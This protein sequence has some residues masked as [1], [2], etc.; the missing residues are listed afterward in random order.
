MS[1]TIKILLALLLIGSGFSAPALAVSA[2]VSGKVT[3]PA[4]PGANPFQGISLQLEKYDAESDSYT[5]VATVAI[6][7]SP[8]PTSTTAPYKFENVEDGTYRVSFPLAKADIATSKFIASSSSVF[9]IADSKI[10]VSGRSVSAIPDFKLTPMGKFAVKAV[11]PAT[12]VP[13]AD[14]VFTLLGQFNGEDIELGSLTAPNDQ[15]TALLPVPIADT[16]TV[17]IV[18]PAGLH[19]EFTIDKNFTN[20]PSSSDNPTVY[21][22]SPA[23]I[24]SVTVTSGGN[25]VVGAVVHLMDVDT[26]LTSAVANASGIATISGLEPRDYTIRVGG[27]MGS[28][29][30]DSEAQPFTINAGATTSLTQQLVA[31]KTIS[32]AVTGSTD[33]ASGVP[34]ANVRVEIY[35]VDADGNESPVSPAKTGIDGT[36]VSNGLSAG[37][38]NLY[39]YDDSSDWQDYRQSES[40]QRVVVGNSN[41]TKQNVNLPSAAVVTGTV[42]TGDGGS[43]ANTLAEVINSF[44]D[45]IAV[46]QV[47]NDGKFRFTK[48]VPGKYSLK[49][50]N[51]NYLTA[52]TKDFIAAPNTLTNKDITLNS[53]S[54]ISGVVTAAK[55]GQGIDGV[56]VSAYLSSGAGLIPALTVVTGMDGSYELS[57]LPAG[58]YR[59]KYDGSGS[60]TPIGIFWQADSRSNAKSFGQ[61]V[62]IVTRPGSVTQNVNPVPATPWTLVT[63]KVLGAG[64]DEN[65]DPATVGLEN[66]TVTLVST[67]GLTVRSADTTA[68]GVFSIAVPDGNYGIKIAAV[69]YTTGYVGSTDGIATLVPNFADAELVSVSAGVAQFNN[70]W[71]ITDWSIDV[72][73]AGGTV[74]VIVTDENQDPVASG[75]LVAYDMQGNSVAFTDQCDDAGTFTL[76]GLRGKYYFSYESPGEFAKRFVGGTVKQSDAGTEIVKVDPAGKPKT[77]KL[78]TVSLPT[79]NLKLVTGPGVN[80][81]P[82]IGDVTVEVYTQKSG[83]WLRNDDLTTTAS[84]GSVALGVASGASYRIRVVPDSSEFAPIWVGA[85]PLATNVN[86]AS[87]ILIPATGKAPTLGNVVLNVSTGGISGEVSDSFA[88]LVPSGQVQLLDTDGKVLQTATTRDDGTYRIYRVLPGTYSL[89]FAAEGLA[90]KYAYNVKVEGRQTT[91]VSMTLNSATGV[92]GLMLTNDGSAVVG[93]S[94]SIFAAGGSGV[95]PINTVSTKSDGSYN[96]TGIPAGTYKIKFDG[97]TAEIP[98]DVFW[99][100][101]SENVDTFKAGS[102]VTTATGQS[103]KNINPQPSNSWALIK[104]TILDDSNVVS[105]ASISLVTSSGTNSSAKVVASDITDENANFALYAPDGQYKI[106]VQAAGFASGFLDTTEGGDVILSPTVNGAAEV[107]VTDNVAV[108]DN[109]AVGDGGLNPEN[110]TLDLA[111]TGGSLTVNVKDENGKAITDGSVT[112]YDSTGNVVAYDDKALSGAFTISGLSG[113]YRFSYVQDGVFAKTFYGDTSDI[114]DTKT[115]SL[116]VNKSIKPSPSAT[117]NVKTL[118]KITVNIVDSAS[119]AASFKQP[120]TVEVYSQ[121]AGTWTLNNSLTQETSSGSVSFGVSNLDQ[122]RIR[123]VPNSELLTPVWVG[124]ARLATSVNLASTITI[125]A[126]GA[127]PT[128]GKVVMNS[129]AGVIQ[130]TVLDQDAAGILNASVSL[131]DNSGAEIESTNSRA[132]GSYRFVQEFPGTY[133]IKIVADGYAVKYVKQFPVVGG[134]VNPIETQLTP[135]TGISGRVLLAGDSQTPVVG[136]AVS[137]YSA[138]GTGNIAIQTVQTDSD[139]NYNFVGLAP[140]NYKVYF[141]NRSAQIPTASFW[142]GAETNSETFKDASAISATLGSYA[143]GV[144][145]VPS[146]AWTLFTGNIHD[147]QWAVVGGSVSLVS[148]SLISLAGGTALTGV[149]DERGNFAIY[150]PDGSYRIKVSAPGY[151]VGYIDASELGTPVLTTSAASAAVLSVS[152]GDLSF[153]NELSPTEINLDLGAHGGKVLVTV[154]DELGQ[155]VSDGVVSA[156]DKSGAVV[157]QVNSSVGG[158]FTLSGLFG[159][160]RLSY[161][162]DGIFAE[163]FL[164]DTNS[165][166]SAG[167]Q[168]TTVTNGSSISAAI[169]VK[170]LPRLTVNIYS[171]GTTAY[172]QPTLVEVYT[173]DAGEWV[174]NPGLTQETSDGVLTLGVVNSSQYRIRLVPVDPALAPIWL[175]SNAS[176]QSVKLAKS[177]LIPAAGAVPAVAGVLNVVSGGLGGLLTDS[178]ENLMPGVTVD[179]LATNSDVVAETKTLEDGSYSF[180]QLYPGTYKVKF[181]LERFADKV[182]SVSVTAGQIT[183][184]D[185]VLDSASG[186]SGRVMGTGLQQAMR[187]V[188]LKLRSM[189]SFDSSSNIPVAGA[190]VG[191]YLASGNG[192]TPVRTVT[193]DENGN[194]NFSGLLPGS[195]RIRIDGN[196]ATKPAERIWYSNGDTNA[197]TF[198]QASTIEALQGELVTDIEPAPIKFWTVFDGLLKAG[199]NSISSGTVTLISTAGDSYSA[200]TDADGFFTLFA[201]DGAYRVRVTAAGYPS[202]YVNDSPDGVILDTVSA[203]ATTLNIAEGNAS[204]TTGLDLMNSPLDLASFGGSL[205]VQVTDGNT[206]LTDGVVTVYNRAGAVVAYTDV[207]SGGFFNIDGLKGDYKVSYE[208]PGSYDLSFI[209]DTKSVSDPDTIFVKVRDK[210]VTSAKVNA[211]A[212]PKFTVSV[213]SGS[214]VYKQ[215][216]SINVFKQDGQNWKL[217]PD[218]G[219]STFTGSYVFGAVRGENYRVQVVPDDL[220]TSAAWV[221]N[222]SALS[223]A[224]ALTYSV[225]ATGAAP[226]LPSV[227]LSPAVQVTIPLKNS[228]PVALENVVAHLEVTANGKLVEFGTQNAGNLAVDSSTELTFTRVP[229][230]MFP[231]SVTGTSSN[232]AEVSS[233]WQG[234]APN[235]DAT[236]DLLEFKDEA[237]PAKLSGSVKTAAGVAIADQLVTLATDEGEEYASTTTDVEGYYSFDSLPLGIHLTVKSEANT[238]FLISS[239]DTT[240]TAR[241]GKE[242]EANFT[243]QDAV[244]FGGTVLDASGNPKANALVNVYQVAGVKLNVATDRVFRVYTD[245]SGTW[246][247]DGTESRAGVGNY[248]F[249]ADGLGADFTP[250]YLGNLDC[251]AKATLPESKA[252]CS[253][254]KPADAV[255]V[256]ASQEVDPLSEITLVLGAPDRT[257]PTGVKISKAPLAITTVSP[258]WEWTGTDSVDG[259]AL[260]SEVLVA[261]AS[262]GKP[263]SAWS[264]PIDVAGKSYSIGGSR[265]ATYC[266]SVSMVDKSGNTSA[267]TAPSC[268]TVAMD[269]TAMKPAVAGLW[270]QAA[271]PGAVAGKVIAAKKNAK[272][273]VLNINKAAAGKSLCVYYVTGA[274]FGAFTVTVNGKALGKPVPTAGKAGQIKSV[275]YKTKLKAKAKIAI[276]VAKAGNGVQIDGYAITIANAPAPAAPVAALR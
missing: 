40:I 95:T 8:S 45:A 19:Q 6:S 83:E 55:T 227:S 259:K 10:T 244:Q 79:L 133:T 54:V 181:A 110:L 132:D 182:A 108:I 171:V 126:S 39:F 260:R 169:K 180:I 156:Y 46:T 257:A 270:A 267:Y 18:D 191:L 229:K 273:A 168:T 26:E 29:L 96:L 188:G 269:D 232:S 121:V 15:G 36:F 172:K 231:I 34:V 236:T 258:A 207:V 242:L 93:A 27:P 192:L 141:N 35:Q 145:P 60:S 210:A 226:L 144:D 218:L 237:I 246:S 37:T 250:A 150:A 170:T 200:Q 253:V 4:A 51:D 160:Y 124:D 275:C 202:G 9:V 240:F 198:A 262:Y 234:A 264:K 228:R 7:P 216:V 165:L 117:I 31:G 116:V 5:S 87:T 205:Q 41:I 215:P 118:P 111:G 143:S 138:D 107:S 94:V 214:S 183:T 52:Y 91:S 88:G 128:L 42:T 21:R 125:P 149:T 195:Y 194:F 58:S 245:S 268:A 241:S 131:L 120:V 222:P 74:H 49:I 159:N 38:Y 61:A 211:I 78:G 243:Q 219:G 152:G 33:T 176:A 134:L 28:V 76:T 256:T 137:V 266:I 164:G 30:S 251:L 57:D 20:L 3:A 136:S 196:S 140:G 158:V 86:N 63:G 99:Y 32:G 220:N 47:K 115:K 142:Y 56:Q 174:I 53:G 173:Q 201:P 184:Q 82:Y 179:L 1:R 162:Q 101:D 265:G 255:I 50:S 25:P 24:L 80:A 92:T 22:P 272:N 59:I 157:A 153:D 85:V 185:G 247:F 239:G 48:L 112:V 249:F 276:N 113:T 177:I 274:K 62:E 2:T 187:I 66:A 84:D 248:A 166:A 14:A 139:G 69:G 206:V 235:T 161:K 119:P 72:S 148:V 254:A 271:V 114:S 193:T 17:K 151:L 178:F 209:G 89:K 81:D 238:G 68:D 204:F 129:V 13:I 213:K 217:Q 97:S 175:G 189:S 104:G 64:V 261:S 155:S 190:V 233:T 106:Q 23:G 43:I 44:G 67:D 186:I 163:T 212:L 167:T 65:G 127:A 11:D 90:I 147:G 154:K 105:E 75:I 123:V 73:D 263:M 12:S 203:N 70:G 102:T 77:R 221:G 135:A 223:V 230:S 103:L 122:Y 199:L 252:S 146:D 71:D 16:Y 130:G 98:T 100:G 224:D 225:Q 109:V 197:D 208:Q